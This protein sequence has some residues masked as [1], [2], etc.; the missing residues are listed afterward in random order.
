MM[1]ALDLASNRRMIYVRKHDL[2]EQERPLIE[3][4]KKRSRT[5]ITDDMMYRI[6]TYLDSGL[7]IRKTADKVSIS[8][9]AIRYWIA[10]NKL[11]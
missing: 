11:K 4:T 5:L 2:K 10:K 1:E 8:E 6:Q 9:S 3:V 7:S